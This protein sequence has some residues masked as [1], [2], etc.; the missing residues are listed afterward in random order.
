MHVHVLFQP[1]ACAI[2][3]A[4]TGTFTAIFC[5]P[6]FGPQSSCT[7]L[8]MFDAHCLLCVTYVMPGLRHHMGSDQTL[9]LSSVTQE[10]LNVLC[11]LLVDDTC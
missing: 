5:E 3:W 9:Q 2:A 7:I 8:L 10:M 11:L 6:P 1:P 4:V